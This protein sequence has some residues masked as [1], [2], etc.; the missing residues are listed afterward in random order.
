MRLVREWLGIN[1]RTGELHLPDARYGKGATQR[2]TAAYEVVDLLVDLDLFRRLRV[3]GQSRGPAGIED[4]RTALR[5]VEGRPFDAPVQRRAGGG[6]TWL[7]DGDRLDEHAVVAI[8]DVA[9][10][11]ATH[12]LATGDLKAARV[13]AETAALAAPYE[14]IPR[15]DLAAVA[16]AEG[17]GSEA[18]RIVREEIANRSDDD[19]A[20]PELTARTE[21]ILERHHDWFDTKAS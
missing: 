9:H 3:R 18:R 8:V 11:V 15:L 6:W 13:A 16:T 7:I 4:L 12:A 14:E 2:K 19:G 20:P 21:E 1:P 5:L 10:L 17:R